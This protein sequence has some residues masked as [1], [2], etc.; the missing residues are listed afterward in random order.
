MDEIML[1]ETVTALVKKERYKEALT[2]VATFLAEHKEANA[3]TAPAYVEQGYI[4]YRMKCYR[5]SLVAADRAIEL[6]P[7]SGAGWVGRALAL[8]RLGRGHDAS[9]A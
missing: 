6:D 9:S 3:Q 5:D 8:Y 4:Y 1:H 2:E 7:D